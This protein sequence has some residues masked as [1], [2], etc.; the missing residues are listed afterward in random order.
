M[1]AVHDQQGARK[2]SHHTLNIIWSAIRWSSGTLCIAL[3]YRTV[4]E[5]MHRGEFRFPQI[6]T[7]KS[8][9]RTL[10]VG[11]LADQIISFFYQESIPLSKKDDQGKFH[12]SC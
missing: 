7:G 4:V 2:T 5:V 6:L 11:H 10:F 12:G 9:L 3:K 1:S 8:P